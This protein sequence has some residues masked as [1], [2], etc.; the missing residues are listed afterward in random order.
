[1][2]L[3]EQA[4]D[5]PAGRDERP[6]TL[7]ERTDARLRAAGFTPDDPALAYIRRHNE[8]ARQKIRA[9]GMNQ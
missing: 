7:A 5:P 2:T 3:A 6:L 8:L 4:A 1:M 9:V